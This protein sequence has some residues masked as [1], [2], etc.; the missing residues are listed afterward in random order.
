LMFNH[1]SEEERKDEGCSLTVGHFGRCISLGY[2]ELYL[3][4]G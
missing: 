4:E 1:Q 3:A 2:Q